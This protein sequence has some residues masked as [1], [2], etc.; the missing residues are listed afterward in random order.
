MLTDDKKYKLHKNDLI[1]IRP[2]KY[3]CIEFTKDTEYSRINIAFSDDAVGSSL[4]AS[5]PLQL[6][7]TNHPE[8][9]IIAEIFGRMDYY[10]SRLSEKSFCDML[11][12]II[13]EILYNLSLVDIDTAHIPAYI[14]PLLARSLEFLNK[15]L[16]T[17][18]TVKQ[19]CKTV[20]VSE[21][22]I[23]RLFRSELHITPHK[24]LTIKR[25]LHA[26]GLLQRGKRPSEIFYQCGFISYVGFYKQY[27][28][29]FGYPPSQE[30]KRTEK[31]FEFSPQS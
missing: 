5:I 3:H 13:K 9:S 1:F 17:Q 21:Q 2:Y 15:N 12:A 25:L 6:E 24:Y 18:N 22:Y 26:Q 20:G 11:P 16:F 28:K 30:Q 14:S 31:Q 4:P 10:T 7:V 29:E 8:G 27:V 23:F 19:L